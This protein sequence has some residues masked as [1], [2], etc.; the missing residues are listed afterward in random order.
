VISSVAAEDADTCFELHFVEAEGA[1]QSAAADHPE[2]VAKAISS[3]TQA[4][5]TVVRAIFNDE[6]RLSERLST[7]THE[8]DS[9]A[10]AIKDCPRPAQRVG[11]GKIIW[12][13]TG[14]TWPPE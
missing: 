10:P 2:V 13:R 7:D 12:Q 6:R 4:R 14:L 1:E 5:K 8:P 11:L 3:L 9:S